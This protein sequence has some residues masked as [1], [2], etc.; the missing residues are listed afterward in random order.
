MTVLISSI[1]GA[2]ALASIGLL[3]FA[4]SGYRTA[5]AHSDVSARNNVVQEASDFVPAAAEDVRAILNALASITAEM[6]VTT[7]VDLER[8]NV[9]LERAVENRA[10]VEILNARVAARVAAAS[11]SN[12]TANDAGQYEWHVSNLEETAR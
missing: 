3:W 1:V 2:I 9:D 12:L 4:V 5:V 11:F 7:N 8:A 10:R 6:N